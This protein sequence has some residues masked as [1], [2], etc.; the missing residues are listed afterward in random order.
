M[1]MVEF[2]HLRKD[3][4]P[5]DISVNLTNRNSRDNKRH[6][7]YWLQFL[8]CTGDS[9]VEHWSTERLDETDQRPVP[10][11][12]SLVC[13]GGETQIEKGLVAVWSTDEMARFINR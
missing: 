2:Q 13:Q 8:I 1:N 7:K 4:F 10:V 6:E 12:I 5:S 3:D 9:L 11:R